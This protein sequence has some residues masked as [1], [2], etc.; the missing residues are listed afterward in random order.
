MHVSICRKRRKGYCCNQKGANPSGTVPA[1][2]P[3]EEAGQV[4]QL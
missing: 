1:E 4:P 3:T 2:T